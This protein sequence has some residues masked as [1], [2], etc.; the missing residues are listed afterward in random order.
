MFILSLQ[1]VMIWNI[2][3]TGS[4]WFIFCNPL[5]IDW[6]LF[7]LNPFGAWVLIYLSQEHRLQLPALK[8]KAHL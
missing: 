5:S 2:F 8:M 1:N 3:Q 4:L 7:T 6:G